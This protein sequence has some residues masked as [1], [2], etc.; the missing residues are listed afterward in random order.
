MPQTYSH[1]AELHLFG[2]N[3]HL[4]GVLVRQERQ[5]GRDGAERRGEKNEERQLFL[6]VNGQF[7]KSCKEEQDAL[8]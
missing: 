5:D 3:A 8:K 7:M 2:E 4:L 1:N 6:R